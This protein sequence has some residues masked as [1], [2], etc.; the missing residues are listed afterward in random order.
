MTTTHKRYRIRGG[1][2]DGTVLDS[3]GAA[4]RLVVEL[5]AGVI[6]TEIV[7]V[8]YRS[9]GRQRLAHELNV[10]RMGR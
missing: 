4:V 1:P 3:Y 2:A 6:H 8:P 5:E 10:Q 7:R 9:V